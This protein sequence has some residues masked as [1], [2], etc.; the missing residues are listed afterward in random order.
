VERAKGKCGEVFAT[1][2]DMS[3]NK[4]GASTPSWFV[5]TTTCAR[6]ILGGNY[7]GF[8]NKLQKSEGFY[9]VMVVVDK[10]SKSA[11]FPT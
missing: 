3:T 7:H 5:K 11:H 9:T 2:W 10:F 6:C 8:H 4:R 1:M